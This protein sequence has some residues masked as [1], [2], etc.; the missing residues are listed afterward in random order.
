[1]KTKTI[2]LIQTRRNSDRYIVEALGNRIDPQVGSVLT[3]PEVQEYIALLDTQVKI[4][5]AK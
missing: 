2:T 1:M 4:K 3:A 5:R